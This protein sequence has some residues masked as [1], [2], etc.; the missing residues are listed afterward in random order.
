MVNL[1]TWSQ[2]VVITF[3]SILSL[4]SL[5]GVTE[6][7]RLALAAEGFGKTDNG[8]GVVKTPATHTFRIYINLARP[9][10]TLYEDGTLL[11]SYPVALGRSDTQTPVGNWRIIDK[12]K[13][14][15]KGFGTRWLGLNVPWGTYGIHG[16][17]RPESIGT[18]SSNGCIRMH[19]ADVERL[20][21]IVPKG[22]PVQIV[23]NPLKHMRTL[24]YGDIGAD[25]QVVQKKLQEL[26]YFRGQCD[27][28][29]GPAMQFGLVYYQLTKGLPMD[30]EV[31]MDDYRALGMN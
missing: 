10:L 18:Y 11:R 12:Q 13:N 27:G 24:K 6:H 9:V 14:W 29:F 20:Y 1:K 28:K 4:G 19:N 17:N 23:G 22:T 25:V 15:G 21:D 16:T 8:S 26:G 30:G 5:L 31:G 2:L 3:A 7:P